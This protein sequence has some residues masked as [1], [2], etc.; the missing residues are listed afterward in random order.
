MTIMKKIWSKLDVL[1][2]M[3]AIVAVFC[4]VFIKAHRA[5]FDLDIW[6]H[7]KTGE[8]IF[9]N[10]HIPFQDIFSFSI[11]GRR[12]ID[13]EWLFQLISYLAYSRWQA[14]GLILLECFM[15]ALTFFVLFVMGHRQMKLYLEV[16]ALLLLTTY[17]TLT[18]FNIRPEIFSLFF[19]AL[20]LYFLRFHIDK[21]V[22]YLLLFIQLLWVNF[23]GFFFFG[24]LLIFFFILAEFLRRKFPYLPEHWRQGFALSDA[25]Y[26]RLKK[27]LL[28]SLLVCLLNPNGLSGA[29]Y[30]FSV[31]REMLLGK[32][33]IFFKHIQE[34]QPTFHMLK[35]GLDNSYYLLV[36]FCILL[37]CLN[38]KKLRIIEI[39]LFGFFFLL[40]L[41]VR[42][43]AYFCFIIYMIIIS[44]MIETL[45][46]L[47]ER[48]KIHIGT[49]QLFYHLSRCAITLIFIVWLG[50]KI[51]ATINSYYYD[52]D[53]KEFK[54]YLSGIQYNRYPKKVVD[55]LLE[56]EITPNLF[57]D[58]NSGAYLIGKAY[59]KIKVFI[60]GRT[61]LY[62]QEFFK[63]YQQAMDGNTSILKKITDKYNINAILISLTSDAKPKIIN[64][65]YKNPN[66][67]LVFFDDS[68]VVFLKDIPSHKEALKRYVVDLKKYSVPKADLKSL[69]LRKIYPSAYIKR[70][71]LFYI[72]EQDDLV[73]LESKEAL[74]I[75]PICFEAYHLLGKAYLR[76]NLYKQALEN[77]RSGLLIIPTHVEALTDLGEC[78][79]KLRENK[80]AI[81]T[82]KGAIGFNRHYAPAYFYLGWVYLNE[83]NE[84]EAI[85]FLRKANRYGPDIARYHLKLG[86]ALYKR[87]GRLKDAHTLAGAKEEFKKARELA[88]KK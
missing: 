12:W 22:I 43:V 41:T 13:H 60:D 44:Y 74:R 82:L 34:L 55:F 53:S 15:I 17:A 75:T 85:K 81:K 39:I 45:G 63:N 66:Y 30:P 23:H 88:L 47:S 68:G 31:F 67:K 57:N 25:A 14:E 7:L 8:F 46:G 27:L 72:L 6:L 2:G 58:F 29:I 38:I 83:H 50:F 9:Q 71:T 73:I 86:E 10:K 54:S 33:Q 59:P 3:L 64:R 80:Y 62:G 4:L 48:I 76:K 87:G 42:N 78:L 69:G 79:L 84:T 5:I 11:Q 26:N 18:R 19:F 16:A 77:L 51:G 1:F 36:F 24:P 70:A 21:R 40:S 52:F 56:N 49:K 65:I 61:E 37:I 32:T 20:Y 28:F 35:P